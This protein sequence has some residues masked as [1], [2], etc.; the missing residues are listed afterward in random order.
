M[1]MFFFGLTWDLVPIIYPL[2]EDSSLEIFF[3]A[4]QS[5]IVVGFLKHLGQK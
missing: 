2:K 3:V 4:G 5:E 1:S